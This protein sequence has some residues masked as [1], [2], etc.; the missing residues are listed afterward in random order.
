MLAYGKIINKLLMAEL[1]YVSS[2]RK[3]KEA[4]K[5]TLKVV[6]PRLKEIL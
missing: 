6:P 2:R 3:L 1:Y 5:E 4:R